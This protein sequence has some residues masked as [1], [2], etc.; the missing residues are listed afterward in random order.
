MYGWHYKPGFVC[1]TP[2]VGL[3]TTPILVFHVTEENRKDKRP[4]FIKQESTE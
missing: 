2:G 1:L 3:V 4:V